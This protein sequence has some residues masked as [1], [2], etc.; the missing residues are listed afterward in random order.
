MLVSRNADLLDITVPHMMRWCDWALIVM[1]NESNDVVDKCLYFQKKFNGRIF[2][3]RSSFPH[4][5]ITKAGDIQDYR[6]RWRNL[7]GYVRDDVFT[8]LNKILEWKKSGYDKID[9]LLWPDSDEIFTDHLPEL[10]KKFWESD[11]KA[12]SLKPVDILNDLRT[13]KDKSMSHHVHILKYHSNYRGWPKRY[14]AR[15]V[16]L[17]TG[18]V[19]RASYYSVHLAYLN[20]DIRDFRSKNWKDLHFMEEPIWILD[21]DVNTYSPKEIAAILRNKPDGIFCDV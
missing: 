12:V 16:P 5:I 7:D 15:Y 9:V 20:K 14:F 21:R 17:E 11:Y 6:R 18:E 2:L 3:R 4:K 8:N 13:I 10:I 1:D 19:M